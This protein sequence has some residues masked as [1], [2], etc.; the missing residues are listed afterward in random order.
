[1][2]ALSIGQPATLRLA[3]R[4]ARLPLWPVAI[5]AVLMASALI[6]RPPLA[7]DEARILSI[8][9]RMWAD[10]ALLPYKYGD[11]SRSLPPLMFWLIEAGWA[12]LGVSEVWARLVNPL[13]AL[14]TL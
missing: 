9:W 6:A 1:A 3:D 5:W 2:M 8:A 7:P 12:V 14:G 10:G 4:L 13:L 11:L